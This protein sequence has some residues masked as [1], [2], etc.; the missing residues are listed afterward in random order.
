MLIVGGDSAWSPPQP[1]IEQICIKFGL[2]GYIEY[3][4]PGADF[5]AKHFIINTVD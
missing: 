5:G 4:E 1:L 3:E 2:D